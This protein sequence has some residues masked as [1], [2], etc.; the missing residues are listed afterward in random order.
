MGHVDGG[1]GFAD[2]SLNIVKCQ[3]RHEAFPWLLS[4]Y[5]CAFCGKLFTRPG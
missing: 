4:N 1:G 5:I 2:P 3:R